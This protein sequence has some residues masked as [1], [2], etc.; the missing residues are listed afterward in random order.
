MNVKQHA[1][2]LRR[3]AATLISKGT[4]LNDIASQLERLYNSDQMIV[5]DEPEEEAPEQETVHIK[6]KKKV[7]AASRQKMAAAQKAR[8]AKFHAVREGAP[9]VTRKKRAMRVLSPSARRKIAAAQRE[10][11]KKFRQMGSQPLP[12]A[13]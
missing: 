3:E 9:R 13:A 6:P 11:W 2:E 5:S 12:K 8:W 7:S 10:R 4:V 1:V